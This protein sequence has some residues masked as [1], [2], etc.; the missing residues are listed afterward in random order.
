MR[1]D[2]TWSNVESN[3]I[4]ALIHSNIRSSP[5]D[6]KRQKRQT[7]SFPKVFLWL[8]RTSRSD[9]WDETPPSHLKCEHL[10]FP[11]AT[12]CRS[13]NHIKTQIPARHRHVAPHTGRFRAYS[14]LPL[15]PH[16]PR[17]HTSSSNPHTTT[18]TSLS[19]SSRRAILQCTPARLS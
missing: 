2:D 11:S 19:K 9:R 6:C 7:A 10:G 1:M 5:A 18:Q 14:H 13:F 3:T 12:L 17:L 16:L 4:A 8:N 15:L